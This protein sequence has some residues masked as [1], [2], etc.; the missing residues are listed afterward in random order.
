[1]TNS[2]NLVHSSLIPPVVL[3]MAGPGYRQALT[4]EVAT[5]E[6]GSSVTVASHLTEALPSH[7]IVGS[8]AVGSIDLPAALKVQ[9]GTTVSQPNLANVVGPLV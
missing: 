7:F 2:W 5:P 9:R 1:M 6:P 4:D 8:V 3:K